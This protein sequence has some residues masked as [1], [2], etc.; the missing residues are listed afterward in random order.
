[1]SIQAGTHK[2]GPSNGSLKIKTGKEGAAAKMGHD[3]VLNV[4][5]WEGT[6]DVG[7]STSVELSA[8]PK[9]VEVESGSGGAKPLGDK[10]K[11]DIKKSIDNKVLGSSQITF[12]S[13]EASVDGGKLNVKGDLSIAGQSDSVSV[14]CTIG[15]DGTVSGSLT[16][17]QSNFGIKQFSAM[18]GALKVKDSV[19]VDIEAKLPTE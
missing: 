19:T 9:S 1:M 6:V 3:L 7:D 11:A 8:D 17:N 15:D 13:S 18:M 12:K 16:F 10:D 5:S 14:P 4:G 2:I